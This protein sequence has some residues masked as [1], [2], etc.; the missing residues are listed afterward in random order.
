MTAFDYSRPQATAER[1]IG[2]FGQ[3]GAIR[4]PGTAT[5]PKHNSTPGTPTDHAARFAILDFTAREVDGSRVLASDKK[6][7]VS[8][9]GLEIDPTTSDSLVDAGGSAWKI[10]GVETL[11]PAETTV[12][13]T[14]QVRK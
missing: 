3:T 13:I 4:R 9:V 11:R 6:A 14:L 5:G 2:R 1:L 12:L 7:L 8:P 10:V